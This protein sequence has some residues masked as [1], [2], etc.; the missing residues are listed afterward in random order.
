MVIIDHLRYSITLRYSLQYL[1]NQKVHKK[2]VPLSGIVESI[3]V[4]YVGKK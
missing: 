1:E 4:T 3:G 2:K